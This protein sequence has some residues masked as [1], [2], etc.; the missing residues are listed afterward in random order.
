MKEKVTVSNK[1]IEKV[2][3]NSFSDEV[4]IEELEVNVKVIGKRA[5]DVLG[6]G[7]REQAK[8]LR[9]KLSD[10]ELGRV[11]Y[12]QGQFKIA[13]KYYK[14]AIEKDGTEQKIVAKAWNNLGVMCNNLDK[15][16]EYYSKA[17]EANDRFDK[18][19]F[20]LGVTYIN[21]KEE[22]KAVNCFNKSIET[23][24]GEGWLKLM[25]LIKTSKNE[26]LF[27]KMCCNVKI[28]NEQLYKVLYFQYPNFI[29]KG[30]DMEKSL[31]MIMKLLVIKI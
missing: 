25:H 6:F 11:A 20:N 17:L 31:S 22:D 14:K 4:P 28:Q 18:A 29:S 26:D 7:E 12:V 23:G 13:E 27:E 30:D 15:E 10:C 2:I 21:K 5:K 19:W 24:N 3:G 16:E 1:F 9:K 8:H